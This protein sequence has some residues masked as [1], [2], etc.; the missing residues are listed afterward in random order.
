MALITLETLKARMGINHN[1]QDELLMQMADGVSVAIERFLGRKLEKAEYIE[2]YNGNGKNHIVLRQY[3]VS[4]VLSVKQNG[5]VLDDVD[6]DDWLL[7]RPSGF[8]CGVRNIEVRYIAGYADVPD[9][10]L[11]AAAQIV[12]QRLNELENKGVQSKTLAGETVT[13]SN[14]SQSGGMPPAALAILQNYKRKV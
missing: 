10:I 14:F 6:F 8:A 2:R 3:P 1:R 13:F 4:N 7:M 11:E 5:R 12:G 9:D